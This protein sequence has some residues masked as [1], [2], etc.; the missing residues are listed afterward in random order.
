MLPSYTL[1]QIC[2]GASYLRRFMGAILDLCYQSL[3]SKL[4]SFILSDKLWTQEPQ[5]THG[6]PHSLLDPESLKFDQLRIRKALLIRINMNSE[7][8]Q[9]QFLI[10]IDYLLVQLQIQLKLSSALLQ[11]FDTVSL[12]PLSELLLQQ[13]QIICVQSSNICPYILS[14]S[15]QKGGQ[16]LASWQLM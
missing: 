9:C 1:Y 5:V 6:D 3:I 12:L 16:V 14:S 11:I 15:V 4:G 7:L 13:V 10:S 8:V 2:T